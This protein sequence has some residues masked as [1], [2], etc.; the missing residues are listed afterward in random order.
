MEKRRKVDPVVGGT[1]RYQC[2]CPY[3]WHY[4]KCKHS[5]AK[6]IQDGSVPIP[7]EYRID[8]IGQVR[9]AGRPKGRRDEAQV[10]QELL[11]VGLRLGREEVLVLLAVAP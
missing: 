1:S 3:F 5:L 10:L 4:H 7:A 6:A 8:L 2:S 9:K 11:V